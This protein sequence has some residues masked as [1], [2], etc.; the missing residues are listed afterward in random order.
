MNW[1]SLEN[2]RILGTVPVE[3]DGSAYFSVPTETFV[4]FQLLDENGMMVQS[5]RSGTVAQPGEVTGCVGCHEERLTAPLASGVKRPLAL[6]RRPSELQKWYGQARLFG[7]T[8]EVQGVF[9]RH[10]V[11]CHDYGKQAGDKLNLSGDRTLVFNMAYNELWRKGYLRCV[12]AGPA[13]IQAAYSWGSHASRLIKEIREPSI[14]EH[15]DVKLGAEDFARLVTW[16]D[17]N[18]VYY[19]TYSCAY[20]E[21]RTGRTPLSK[22]QLDRLGQLTGRDFGR[23]MNYSTNRGVEVNFDRPELSFCLRGL[24]EDSAEYKEALAI[25]RAGKTMLAKRPRADMNGFEPCETDRK[26][27]QKYA[28]RREV[29]QRNRRAIVRREKMYD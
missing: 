20:P 27:E 4:Y 5:M 12:G 22:A 17:L 10:C 24:A 1:H 3:E 16:V 26:R 9:D 7:F 21:S 28:R 25:I 29:E 2:K 6:R 18:A 23:L 13:P 11:R 14:T 8:A 15:A 19:P